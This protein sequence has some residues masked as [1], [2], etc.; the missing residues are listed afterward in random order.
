MSQQGS[1][2]SQGHA[3]MTPATAARNRGQV[4]GHKIDNDIVFS[5]SGMNLQECKRAARRLG[6]TVERIH[7]TGE[8]RFFHP[9]IGSSGMINNRR[10][11]APR[12]ATTW[13]RRLER[14]L[15]GPTRGDG[16]NSKPSC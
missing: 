5:R 13:L 3:P 1:H 11:D 14:V 7:R 8:I 6:A 15:L 2:G 16:S 9:A 4:G 12:H 10:K